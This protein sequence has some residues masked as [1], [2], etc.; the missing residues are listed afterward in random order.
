MESGAG[1]CEGGNGRMITISAISERMKILSLGWG[2][3]SFTIAAM[4]ALGD[5]EPIDYAIHADTTHESELT[6]QFAARWTGWLE[7]RG[8]KV[9]TVKAENAEAVDRC[10][11][12]MIPAYIDNDTKG[13][14]DRQ[15][16]SQWKIANIRRWLQANR[17][18]QVVEQWIGISLDEY[19]RM[20]PSGVKYIVNRWPLIEKRMTRWDC[21]RWLDEHGLDIPSKSA[22]IFCPFKNTREWRQIQNNQHEWDEVLRVDK[23][24][25]KTRPPFDL[26]LHPSRK[27]IEQVD[28]RTEQE[29]GQLNL[30]DEECTGICGV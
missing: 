24:I 25:R 16:T 7:A 21:M 6:Y 4:V 28:L 26:Y 29:Q 30:W 12:V 10:G 3:Q 19:Q 22:C 1:I 14:F 15:C 18:K 5:L 27:P 2:V 11:G 9:I 20:K 23:L 8:V 13:R 17:N